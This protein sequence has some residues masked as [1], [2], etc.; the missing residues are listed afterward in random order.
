MKRNQEYKDSGIEWIG[1]I[2]SHWKTVR[3]SALYDPRNEKA[4]A[5]NYTPLSVTMQGIVPQLDTAAKSQDSDNR[6]LVRSGD[7]VINSRS[8]RRGSCG[9][10]P[11]DG[12]V[13]LI[14][15]VLAPKASNSFSPEYYGLLFKTEGFADEYYRCGT[16]IV[17]DLWSTNWTRMKNILV[18]A[19][20]IEEQ[21]AIAKY[22]RDK[23]SEIDSL[24]VKTG[25]SIE[26]LEE[27]R[28]SVIS[29]TVTKGLDPD[30][31]MKDS[32]IEWIGEI[33]NGWRAIPLK[34]LAENVESGRSVDGANYPAT[35]TEIG[36]LTLSS[37]YRGVFDPE[38]NKAVDDAS[39]I[40]LLKCSVKGNSLLVSRCNTSEWV[41]TAALVEADY[42]NLF[43]PDKIW[44]LK[45]KSWDLCRWIWYFLQSNYAR[46]YFAIKSVGASSTM[47][48]I[49]K[50]DLLS[51][52]ILVPT[53]DDMT[54]ALRKLDSRLD[55]IE[56]SEKSLG[57][58]KET[59][60]EY[61]KSL[62]SEAVTGKLK[63]P[64]VI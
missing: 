64:G 62:I 25:K 21:E 57:A 42:D 29:E 38:A 51:L 45:F 23:T 10:A 15:N 58:L 43:L 37:V 26:L 60:S 20:P 52:I 33:P 32:G 31:G 3:I 1:E 19:P 50:D 40:E 11:Q 47:Q 53:S 41:G 63:V 4:S 44:Q 39:L 55:S 9:I 5:E 14:S 54:H 18:V 7:F 24:I 28:K 16:G 46:E 36:V 30:A 8:D 35:S 27:Y 59:L 49:S 12:T 61:R 17:D 2:P 22:L 48:N 34:Y 6:K 56:L 13:S